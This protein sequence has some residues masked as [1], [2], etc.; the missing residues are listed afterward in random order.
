MSLLVVGGIG[1][2]V[3]SKSVISSSVDKVLFCFCPPK[4]LPCSCCCVMFAS[5]MRIALFISDVDG[6]F[7]TLGSSKTCV[8]V[9]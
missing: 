5:L 4:R 9:G 1:V 8:D 6:D 3:S 7:G 2:Q